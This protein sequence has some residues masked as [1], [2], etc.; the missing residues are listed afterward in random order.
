M[1]KCVYMAYPETFYLWTLF[2]VYARSSSPEKKQQ[3]KISINVCSLPVRELQIMIS[4]RNL[5][6]HYLVSMSK[7]RIRT[8]VSRHRIIL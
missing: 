4:Y 2:Q 5:S 8:E 7:Q 3:N 1:F 6:K